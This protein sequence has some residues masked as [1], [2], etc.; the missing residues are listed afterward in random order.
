MTAYPPQPPVAPDY[1]SMPEPG[2]ARANG[3]ALASLICSIAGF[4]VLFLGGLAGVVL[5]AFALRRS[6]DPRV[7]GR[8]MAIAGI[9]IGLLSI[10]TSV[11]GTGG[12]YFG[13]RAGWRASEPPRRAARQFVQDLSAGNTSAVESEITPDITPTELDALDA[14]LHPQGAFHDMTSSEIH[15]NDANGLV[16]CELGGVAN[17]AKG[18][19]TY[20]LTLK[21]VGGVWKVSHA[22]FR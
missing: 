14:K 10:L 18:D 13:I 1:S 15:I 5:G 2:P 4:C 8:G 9:I 12:I 22:E 7:G 20:H 19:E 3:L 16:T 6:R 11:L 21:R 17:F